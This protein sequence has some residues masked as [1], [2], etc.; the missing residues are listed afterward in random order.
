MYQGADFREFFLCARGGMERIRKAG[1][2]EDFERACKEL[3]RA[4]QVEF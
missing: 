1:G 4:L 2:L 3:T